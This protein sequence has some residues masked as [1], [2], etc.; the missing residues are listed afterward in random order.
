MHAEAVDGGPVGHVKA[1]G[2][3]PGDTSSQGLAVFKWTAH[4]TPWTMHSKLQKG[5]TGD[6][7]LT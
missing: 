6:R 5:G 3:L 1:L 7:K 4:T 2:F